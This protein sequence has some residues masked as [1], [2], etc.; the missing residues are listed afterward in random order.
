MKTE[1]SKDNGIGQKPHP[2]VVQIYEIQSPAEAELMIELGVDHMGSVILSKESWRD[3][4]LQP[5]FQISAFVHGILILQLIILFYS[6]L[7]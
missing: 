4:D 5:F 2:L 7:F 6:S 1:N 3:F